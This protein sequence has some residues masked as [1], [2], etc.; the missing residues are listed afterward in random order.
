MKL[1][2]D[3]DDL[4]PGGE[5]VGRGPAGRPIYV[6]FAAPGDRVQVEVPAGEG[7]GHA[8]LLRVLRPGA[9]RAAPPCRHFG[10][11]AEGEAAECGGCEWLHVDY[12]RQLDAKARSFA[13][14][15]RRI[16]RLEPGSFPLLPIVP[17]PR[18]L[19]YRCRAKLHFD[20]ASGRLAFFRRRSHAPVPLAECHLLAPGLD[21]LRE[22]LGPALGQARLA[23]REVMLEWSDAEGRGAAALLLPEATPAVAR[24][25]EGL[26]RAVPGLAGLVLL[27][28]GRPPAL[29]GEPVLR[30]ARD[31]R[32]PAAGLQRSRPDVFQQANRGANA[33]LV[34]AALA[35]LRPAGARVLELY[36]GAGN[37]TAPLA[38]AAASV[39]AVEG[40][41]P[42]LELARRDL[43]QAKVRF[44]AGD[45]LAVAGGLA[46]DP[47]GPRFEAALLDPPRDG[48]R[49]VGPLLARLEVARAV[50]VSCDP[51]TFARDLR[52][53][54]EAGYRVASAQP[55]DLFPQTH[56]VEGLALLER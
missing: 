23:P 43:A 20:R 27:Q 8:E 7:P 10:P 37:F 31:P 28:E 17:S 51:A 53:C 36:C 48:A 33:L 30:H 4:A 32:D 49:G 38:R 47:G 29:L 15:L 40:L 24:R 21:A 50:Y 55:F 12:A 46:R 6:P 9:A 19:R 18:P 45:A 14:T 39:T 2:L 41:G 3:I 13:E 5:A 54:V 42:S 16:G 11:A 52:G 26:L 1:E 56:H 22:A 44:V 35:L 34:E 25:A